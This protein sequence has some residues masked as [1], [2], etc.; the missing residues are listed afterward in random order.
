MIF[1]TSGHDARIYVLV[2]ASAGDCCRD[3]SLVRRDLS[4]AEVERGF[5]R[6]FPVGL[7]TVSL[8]GTSVVAMR[9]VLLMS[10]ISCTLLHG[11]CPE[12]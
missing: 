6:C 12:R 3:S 4:R 1:A 2:S 11:M 5:Y 8:P 10:D 9:C 7:D